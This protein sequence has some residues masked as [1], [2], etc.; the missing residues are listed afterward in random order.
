LFADVA[1]SD[2]VAIG[3]TDY[4][5]RFGWAPLRS[6]RSEGFKYIEA[7]R[8]ELYNLQSDPKELQNIFESA[9]GRAGKLSRLLPEKASSQ[10]PLASSLLPDPKD[11]VEEQNLLHTAM[12]ASDDNRVADARAAYE[13]VLQ[14]EPRSPLALQ[15]LG[16]LE[17]QA[18]EFAKAAEHLKGAREVRPGDSASALHE[19]QARQKTGD[20]EGARNALEASLKASPNQLSARLL[21]GDVYLRLK[22]AGAAA[23]QFEAAQLLDS[24]SMDAQL[25]LARAQIAEGKFAEAVRQLQPLAKSRNAET[26]DLLA[27]A[28]Q[29]LGKSPEAQAAASKAAKLRQRK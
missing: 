13:K 8:P 6:V 4:P 12:L 20:L 16:E 2:L 1:N 29:G 19:G 22:N 7:P 21:L 15:G 28:Y 11:K 9:S 26:F 5:L 17:F 24:R 10:E 25:G 18:S 23:D 3:E 14:L 27:Q